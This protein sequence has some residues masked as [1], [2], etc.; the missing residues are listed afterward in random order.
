MGVLGCVPK[1]NLAD[2]CRTMGHDLFFQPQLLK[3]IQGSGLDA[4]GAP[5]ISRLR[6]IINVRLD[7]S[8]IDIL[9]SLEQLR[10]YNILIDFDE[11]G[12][13]LQIITKHVVER[14]SVFLEIIQRRNFDDFGAG[15]FKSLFE[16]FERY[17][18]ARGNL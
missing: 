12:Y 1:C 7:A 8:K 13:L 16:A 18:E 5:S 4:V 3:H 6:A 2:Q 11:G 14:P 15:N 17:Q 10:K 9:E